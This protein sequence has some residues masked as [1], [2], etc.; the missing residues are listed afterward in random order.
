MLL[1]V[2]LQELAIRHKKLDGI[3]TPNASLVHT[4]VELFQPLKLEEG[5]CMVAI[6][7]GYFLLESCYFRIACAHNS[8]CLDL[9]QA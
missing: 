6:S 1:D 9:V 2:L 8:Y 7:L 3:G 5:Y 4:F